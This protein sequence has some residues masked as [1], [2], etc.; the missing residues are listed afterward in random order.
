MARQVKEATAEQKQQMNVLAK[1]LGFT[2]YGL[3]DYIPPH[4][5]ANGD[6]IIQ[7]YWSEDYA[8]ITFEKTEQGYMA[9]HVIQYYR[10]N[11]VFDGDTS[12]PIPEELIDGRLQ[13]C[14]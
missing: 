2:I 8:H 6:L 9:T 7:G 11:V 10:N 5:R 1:H 13:V 14:P 12:F 4:I 3:Y